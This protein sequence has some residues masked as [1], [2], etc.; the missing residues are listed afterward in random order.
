MSLK[1]S[2]GAAAENREEECQEPQPEAVED[3]LAAEAETPAKL[4]RLQRLPV[5]A[6]GLPTF[7]RDILH[8]NPDD[9]KFQSLMD[10]ALI[11]DSPA[12]FMKEAC[13]ACPF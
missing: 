3:E 8:R 2:S 4:D 9:L 1:A 10:D 12:S 6:P 7:F 13:L 11:R 5:L